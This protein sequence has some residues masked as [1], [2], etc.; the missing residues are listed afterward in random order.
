MEESHSSKGIRGG[1]IKRSLRTTWVV[2]Q[3]L[4]DRFADAMAENVFV[5]GREGDLFFGTALTLLGILS[6][7]SSKFCDGNTADYLSCTRPTAYHYYGAPQ[8][9]IIIVGVFFIL[10]W[11]LKR[12]TR[13]S[14]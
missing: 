5:I 14:S 6:F 12:R 3:Y 4:F 13:K 7:Q 2:I 10:F 11:F 1:S 8:I 9:I